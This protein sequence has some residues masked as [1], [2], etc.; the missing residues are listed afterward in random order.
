MSIWCAASAGGGSPASAR[1]VSPR[2]GATA[3]TAIFAGHC[4][5]CCV[6][7]S[8]SPACRPLAS[9][10]FT[11]DAPP[12][13]AVRPGAAARRRQAP[14]RA[15]NRRCRHRALRAP[16]DRAVAAPARAGQA[17]EAADR[18]DAR[19]GAPSRSEE[20]TSELQ[21][22]CNLVCRLLLEKKNKIINTSH[23]LNHKYTIYTKR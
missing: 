20:H 8:I 2:R 21:S 13:R 14:A 17:L 22:P 23:H 3:V 5:I 6:S 1:A 9:C 16:D 12:S 15:G 4:V 19:Q 11:A 18:G 7:R 10:G